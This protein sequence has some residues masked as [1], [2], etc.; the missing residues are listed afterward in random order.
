MAAA[1]APKQVLGLSYSDAGLDY[2]SNGLVA[3]DAT[4]QSNPDLVRRFVKATLEGL[5]CAMANPKEAGEI[6]HKL[7]REIDVRQLPSA[8]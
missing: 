4:I 3:S 6:L 7:H 8:K 5:T 2:Y 1:A